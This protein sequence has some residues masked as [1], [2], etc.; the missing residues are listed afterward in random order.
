MITEQFPEQLPDNCFLTGI[1]FGRGTDDKSR[2]DSLAVL[3]EVLSSTVKRVIYLEWTVTASSM[4][5]A[6]I[7]DE[8]VIVCSDLRPNPSWELISYYRG[9]YK[10]MWRMT[11]PQFLDDRKKFISMHMIVNVAGS[12]YWELTKSVWRIYSAVNFQ[13]E[14]VR[15]IYELV[16]WWVKSQH[17]F[18]RTSIFK[19]RP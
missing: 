4:F 17:F 5:L 12:F 6:C 2:R 16:L 19:C 8:H 3:G 18:L 7:M 15:E 14:Y 11:F 10:G 13:K 9:S 1:L